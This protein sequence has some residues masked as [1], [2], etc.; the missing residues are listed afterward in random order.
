MKLII[1]IMLLLTIANGTMAQQEDCGMVL[2]QEQVDYMDE[3]RPV[4]EQADL[5]AFGDV[6]TIPFV[7][8]II[9]TS[10]GT[11]GLSIN[12]LNLALSQMNMAYQTVNFEFEL[13][14]VNYIDND[15]HYGNVSYST[16]GTS[17]EYAM[18]VPNLVSNAV[19]VFFVPNANGYCGWSS[20]PAYRDA[21]GKDWTVMANSCAT[22]GSTLAHEL[23][24]YFN[25]Y[26]T[27]QGVSSG[28]N[29]FENELVNRSNCGP[30]VG[31]EL[32]DTSADPRLSGCVN[33]SC[34][35]ICGYV[36]ANG[37]T[38]TPDPTNIM[39]YSLKSCRTFFSPQQIARMQQSYLIDRNYLANSCDC[40]P[41][42]NVTT[43]YNSGDNIDLEASNTITASNIINSG[44]VADYDAG[45]QIDLVNGFHARYGCDFD[46]FI[47][48]CS[49]LLD[50]RNDETDGNHTEQPPTVYMTDEVVLRN[51][52][53]PFTGTTTIEYTLPQAGKISMKIS[54]LSGKTVAYPLQDKVREAGVHVLQFDANNLSHGVY[55][56]I[57]QTA[58][59]V[60][61]HKI[62]LF[63]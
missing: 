57:L 2:S 40:E 4:R 24:H 22:N 60:K 17:E 8:H 16:S 45:V 30:N 63:E 42:I 1:K 14:D 53:N 26:H 48:G 38:Y 3:T 61:T 36:D 44:A 18:A 13:C 12:N 34:V 27:H 37:D 46:A 19:N 52:P 31:D 55:F 5:N 32:C 41:N 15:D 10:G 39:S 43:T 9:R 23:G 56:C 33:S 49:A 21:F 20:F 59:T 11:G 58:N 7:A 6:T 29:I 47:D 35:Y 51:Y 25:L 28:I 50:N 62:T 54:D